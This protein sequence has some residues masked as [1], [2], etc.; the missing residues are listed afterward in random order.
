MQG[1]SVFLNL[2]VLI[3]MCLTGIVYL[4]QTNFIATE[5]YKIDV[6]KKRVSELGAKNRQLEMSALEFQSMLRIENKVAGLNM[7]DGSQ[8]AHID[9][10]SSAVAVR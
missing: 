9:Q 10:V 5:G 2:I 1:R 7:V 6:L 3:V 8:V 4:F